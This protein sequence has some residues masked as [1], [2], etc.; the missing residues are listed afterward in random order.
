MCL[1]ECVSKGE[2][3][4]AFVGY[5]LNIYLL[6]GAE[7]EPCQLDDAST[8]TKISKERRALGNPHFNFVN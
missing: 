2:A 6:T 4:T 3:G 1:N 8:V 5:C 7:T